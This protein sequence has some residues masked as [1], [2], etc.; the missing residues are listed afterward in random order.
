MQVMRLRHVVTIIVGLCFLVIVLGG[1][2]VMRSLRSRT[3]KREREWIWLNARQLAEAGP[4]SAELQNGAITGRWIQQGYLLFS[5]TFTFHLDHN[6]GK[7]ID[8]D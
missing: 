2:S 3:V 7:F 5:T 1:P 4:P 6:T 8:K